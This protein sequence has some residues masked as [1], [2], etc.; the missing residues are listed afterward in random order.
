IPERQPPQTLVHNGIAIGI[1]KRSKKRAGSG[2]EGVDC[3]ISKISDQQI[4]AERPKARR[5]DR[6]TPR[7]IERSV[8]NEPLLQD[9]VRIEYIDDPVSRTRDIVVFGAILDSIR[10]VQLTVN[11][12]DV[13]WSI[14]AR[15]RWIAE[16]ARYRD[17]SERRIKNIDRSGI[18]VSDIEV[19]PGD[20]QA[21]VNGAGRGLIYAK[22]C[23][24]AAGPRRHRPIF[25]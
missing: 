19:V 2:I 18:E 11:E 4:A 3:S 22:R 16:S 7:R 24:R 10:N 25:G 9:T 15:Q 17:R 23:A 14:A 1:V 5:S 8:G 13:E 21:F 12:R 6:E 20:C